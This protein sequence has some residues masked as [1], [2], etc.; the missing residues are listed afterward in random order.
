MSIVG[1]S[2]PL[3]GSFRVGI[4]DG[5]VLQALQVLKQLA[6]LFV[7][8]YIAQFLAPKFGGSCDLRN[9]IKWAGYSAV[10]GM[11]L[12]LASIFG[13]AAIMMFTGIL[14]LPGMI[15]GLAYIFG[16]AAIMMITCILLL[17][18]IYVCYAGVPAMTGISGASRIF[19]MLVTAIC[20]IIAGVILSVIVRLVSPQI[21]PPGAPPIFSD[22]QLDLQP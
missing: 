8:G 15:W 22:Q 2:L 21:A 5:L 12:G 4:V 14:S 1:V 7:V 19:F 9:G 18:G 10:P 16:S 3:V 11:I 17:W 20:A 13:S 6:M